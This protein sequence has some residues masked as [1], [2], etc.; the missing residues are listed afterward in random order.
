VFGSKVQLTTGETVTADE[1]YVRESILNPG[2]K[3]VAGYQNIM[4]TFQGQVTEED[5][6]Q[7]IEYIKSLA[8]QPTQ[9]APAPVRRAEAKKN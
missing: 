9:P 8:K 4:P 5:L 3:I 7:L 1:A 6:L 2:A